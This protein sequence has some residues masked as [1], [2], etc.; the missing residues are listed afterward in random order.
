MKDPF[1]GEIRRID[2]EPK[3]EFLGTRIYAH[4]FITNGG[5]EIDVY[6]DDARLEAAFLAAYAPSAG[7]PP[8][9]VE[10]YYEAVGNAKRVLRVTLDRTFRSK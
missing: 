1:K 7:L 9:I 6:T 4:V 3:Q 2:F 5:D 10:V 8:R